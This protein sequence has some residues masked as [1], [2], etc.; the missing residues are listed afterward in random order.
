MQCK[1]STGMWRHLS[2]CSA[3]LWLLMMLDWKSV[4][5]E[6]CV[7]CVDSEMLGSSS[8]CMQ[9][10]NKQVVAGNVAV[11]VFVVQIFLGLQADGADL[12]QPQQ[13]LAEFICLLWV[14]T[15]DVI[16]QRCV[17]LL[18]NALHQ[19]EVLQVLHI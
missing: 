3:M 18:L 7:R 19:V 1:H 2:A 5:W 16:K 12:R 15:H 13:Q 14:V 8:F 17:H 11:Q 4:V 10:L 9:H 6:Q